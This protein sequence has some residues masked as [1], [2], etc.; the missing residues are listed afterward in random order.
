MV[1]R[2]TISADYLE[3]QKIL[4]QNPS[5]GIASLSFAPIVADFSLL[6]FT[7]TKITLG[8]FPTIL[9]AL[10]KSKSTPLSAWVTVSKKSLR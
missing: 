9:A 4:H 8:V 7:L 1:N 5:Y 3:Q 6:Y 2:S 10:K